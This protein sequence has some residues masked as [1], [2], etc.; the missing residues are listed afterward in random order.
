MSKRYFFRVENRQTGNG[1]WYDMN[2]RFTGLIHTAF[3]FCKNTGLSM[4]FDRE[5]QGY[6]SVTPTIEELYDWFPKEDILRLSEHGYVIARYK[7]NDVKFHNG[8]HLILHETAI[9]AG[10]IDI[11]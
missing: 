6:L 9:F 8:H 11:N 7:S 1:L 5:I 10:L 2:G 4:P 3:S